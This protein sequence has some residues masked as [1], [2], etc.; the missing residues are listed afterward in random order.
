MPFVQNYYAIQNVTSG[1][2][3]YSCPSYNANST[4]FPIELNAALITRPGRYVII[5]SD[6]AITNYAGAT[7]S[8]VNGTN[9]L[10]VRNITPSGSSGEVVNYGGS[11][12]YC[13]VVTV[14]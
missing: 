3:T 7:A 5:K 12:K 8:F 9:G 6:S 1:D 11:N 13:I 10:S 4:P 14:G 2:Y